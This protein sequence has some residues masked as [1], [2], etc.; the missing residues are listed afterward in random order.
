MPTHEARFAVVFLVSCLLSGG[1]LGG[2]GAL[3]NALQD[4]G[5]TLDETESLYDGAFEIMTVCTLV[6]CVLLGRLG[7][8]V[9]SVLGMVLEA[10]GAVLFAYMV[11][12]RSHSIPL[13]TAAL[14]AV[15]GGGNMLFISTFT[16]T[17]W[18]PETIARR[19]ALLS[20]SM[21]VSGYVFLL[22]NV[23]K[24]TVES[25]FHAVA[26]ACVLAVPLLCWCMPRAAGEAGRK[27]GGGGDDNDGLERP[28]VPGEEAR[29]RRRA[30]AK[31]APTTRRW[32]RDTAFHA[33]A[34]LRQVCT[35]KRFVWFTLF[36]S[37][38]ALVNVVT[39]G[40]VCRLVEAAATAS[41]SAASA[42]LADQIQSVWFPVIGNLSPLYSPFIGWWV[43]KRGLNGPMGMMW[44]TTTLAA[45]G[46]LLPLVLGPVSTLGAF[47]GTIFMISMMQGFVYV[48]LPLLLP[49]LP[50]LPQRLSRSLEPSFF[51]SGTRFSSA[52]S[53]S[54]SPRPCSATCQRCSS[55]SRPSS[56]SWRGRGCCCMPRRRPCRSGSSSRPPSCSCT[57]LSCTGPTKRRWTFSARTCTGWRRCGPSRGGSRCEDGGASRP[58]VMPRLPGN[59]NEMGM[60]VGMGR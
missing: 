30:T 46:C 47:F 51:L 22:F 43:D 26:I 40:L 48:A 33:S 8:R 39:M 1:L 44:L 34:T 25:M 38:A 45:A 23:P 2:S 52:T 7:P 42:N 37:W 57:C 16:L 19:T 53:T 10:A 17:R 9:L 31:L 59:G 12:A 35:S 14:G 54:R 41:G 6:G 36:F 21:N 28:L 50:L 27:S 24:V 20:A 56:A 29:T 58:W 60:H 13:L 5:Y 3:L 32:R 11:S 18:F 55:S 15:A 49:L 4:E